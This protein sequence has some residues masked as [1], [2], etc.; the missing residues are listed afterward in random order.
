[1]TGCLEIS[2]SFLVQQCATAGLLNAVADQWLAN[3]TTH[4]FRVCR[5]SRE[6][7]KRNT[8]MYSIP[9]KEQ[10]YAQIV[11][12]VG[13]KSCPMLKIYL[14]ILHST[15]QASKFTCRPTNYITPIRQQTPVIWITMAQ[16][17]WQCKT[18]CDANLLSN[19]SMRWAEHPLFF[20][21]IG[22]WEL[23]MHYRSWASF[24]GNL[25]LFI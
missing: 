2:L 9:N 22:K 15:A 11:T 1:M 25:T 4:S 14:C 10:V 8:Y 12:N 17:Q 5:H 20:L 16:P 7:N 6:K 19:W 23:K 18:D 3:E 21:W 24:T 13:H